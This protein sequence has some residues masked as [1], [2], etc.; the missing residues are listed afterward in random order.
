V[1]KPYKEEGDKWKSERMKEQ[2]K[3]RDKW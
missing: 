1:K 2:I 3:K